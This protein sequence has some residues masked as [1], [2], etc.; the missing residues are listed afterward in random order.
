M[1]D[2]PMSAQG[3]QEG[4]SLEAFVDGMQRHQDATR[5]RLAQ[6]ALQPD[7]REA[8]AR[9]SGVRHALVMTEDWCGDSLLNVPILAHIAAAAPGM[10]LRFFPRALSPDLDAYY[11]A[12][13]I[14]HIPVFT[15]LDASFHERATWVE[16]PQLAHDRLAAWNAAHPEV[17]A[18]RND[19]SLD[20]DAR[21]Q[22]LR[23]LT[24]GLL[25]EMEVWYNDE[26]VQ[27]ATVDEIK[28]LLISTGHQFPP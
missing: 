23:E 15:F 4:L 20:P 21:R 27:Q 26:G 25:H 6:I 10:D 13:G 9:L 7:D 1:D 8:F 22:Q 11:Q 2:F 28:Q 5:R 14:T 17:T 12:R 16:R 18:V 19:T 24:A 3:W